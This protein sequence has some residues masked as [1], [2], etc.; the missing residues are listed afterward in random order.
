MQD[1]GTAIQHAAAQV[2]D[3]L[4][5][6]AARRLGLPP[7]QLQARDGAAVAPDGRRLGYGELVSDQILHVRAQ[8][9]SKL[10]DPASHAVVGKAMPRVDIPGKLTGAPSYVHDLRLP[11]MVHARVVR[12]PGRGARLRAVD[13]ARVESMPGVLKVVRDG[14]WLAVIAERE[15]QAVQAWRALGQAATWVAPPAMPEQGE[16][17]SFLQRLPSQDR[18]ILD[19]RDAHGVPAHTLEAVYQRHYQM[20]GS[21]GPS[22]AVALLDGDRLTVWSHA[23]GMF[24]LRKSIAEML[25]MPPEKVRCIHME[26]AGCYGHNGA[27]DAGADAALLAR[28]LPG[29]PVRVQWMREDEHAWEP[30]GSAMVS[31]AKAALDAEGNIVDWQ[32]EVWSCP[33]ST[34]PDGAGGL[35]PA[36]H[37][38]TPFELPVPKPIP[39]PS[40]GGDRNAVPLY[41]LP[42]A[43]VVHHYITTMPLRTSALRALGGYMN[44]FALESFM[45]ELADAAGVDP[46]AFRLRHLEDKRA[47]DVIATAAERFRWSSAD[48]LPKGRGRG[49]GFARY[50]NT[51]A[52]TAVAAEVEVER[53]SGRVRL[54]RAVAANDCGEVVNPDGVRNQIE[55]AIV[56]AA[57]WTLHEA[58]RFNAAQILSRDWSSYP[59]L[60]FRDL[61]ETVE[62]HL[63]DRPGERFLGTGESGQGPAAAAIANAVARATGA[64]IRTLPLTAERVKAAIGV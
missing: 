15:Y 29:R 8:P 35:M 56:Q 21:I 26:G 44:V 30:F 1:S 17:F 13:A 5:T 49:F 27:D 7:E 22:C 63:I 38:E 43:R 14:S 20:H 39:Q 48:T 62:V 19:R 55:G 54:V 61:P 37:L 33:H 41:R 46:V 57:S 11:N 16:I 28:A 36:W 25:R 2:R 53:E 18:V 58:V 4:I 6:A 24:P 60:R 51:A 59:I 10:K 40:G 3:I 23:Q 42:A 9:A 31:Q 32:Y 12:P 50:K 52:Y 47:R 45:D 34:R 64:R